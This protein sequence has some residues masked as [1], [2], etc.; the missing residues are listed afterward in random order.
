MAADIRP[1]HERPKP[2]LVLASVPAL[3]FL[4]FQD[5]ADGLVLADSGDTDAYLVDDGSGRLV[6]DDTV[7]AGLRVL[8]DSTRIAAL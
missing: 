5:D 8:A 2:A 6:L 7:T 4:R 3:T 1:S